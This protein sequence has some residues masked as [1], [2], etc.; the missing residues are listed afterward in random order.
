MGGK[1]PRDTLLSHLIAS[2]CPGPAQAQ[3]IQRE[4]HE[5]RE[6]GDRSLGVPGILPD[7]QSLGFWGCGQEGSCPCIISSQLPSQP[8]VRKLCAGFKANFIC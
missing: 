4:Q 6:E 7:R 5:P 8:H 3:Q 1:A 2:P